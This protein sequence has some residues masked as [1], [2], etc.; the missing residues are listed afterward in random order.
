MDWPAHPTLQEPAVR[1][2]LSQ[3]YGRFSAAE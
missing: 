3:E 2:I 1:A